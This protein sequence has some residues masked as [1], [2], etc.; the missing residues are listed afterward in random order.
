MKQSTST[1]SLTA[2]T[3]EIPENTCFVCLEIKNELAEPLVES[4]V[5]RTCGCKFHVH[6]YC[7][8]EWK[9]DKTD[10]DCPI[11]RQKSLVEGRDPTPAHFTHTIQEF[12]LGRPILYTLSILLLGAVV[13]LITG[14]IIM[15]KK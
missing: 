12:Q 15:T 11:C 3:E 10:W 4:S 5:L 14:F 7:W 1:T 9:K 2:L 6:P 13:G 8:N